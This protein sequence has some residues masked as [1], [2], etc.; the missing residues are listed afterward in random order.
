MVLG[1]LNL[2]TDT[3]DSTSHPP[4]TIAVQLTARHPDYRRLVR[5]PDRGLFDD[6][7]L[8]KLARRVQ[9]SGQSAA[10][11]VVLFGGASGVITLSA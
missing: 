2:R 3:D 11:A 7:A 5:S 4:Q 1:D 10:R 6:V 9:L 8:L